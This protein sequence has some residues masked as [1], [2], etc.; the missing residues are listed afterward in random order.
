[1]DAWQLEADWLLFSFR[2]FFLGFLR[3]A[4]FGFPEK[5]SAEAGDFFLGDVFGVGLLLGR[6]DE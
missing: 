6:S 4:G 3:L 1:V 5:D 2:S